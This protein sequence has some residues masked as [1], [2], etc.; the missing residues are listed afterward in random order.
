LRPRVH[1]SFRVVGR[2]RP[3]S[4]NPPCPLSQAGAITAAAAA[5]LGETA[6]AADGDEAAA[7][8]VRALCR[9]AV[10]DGGAAEPAAQAAAGSALCKLLL[11]GRAPQALAQPCAASA[12]CALFATQLPANG[13]VGGVGGAPEDESS[14]PLGGMR[15]FVQVCEGLGWAG[16]MGS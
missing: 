15:Q 11:L 6:G 1:D 9:A 10:R 14:E 8:C 5:A 3:S 12:L 2:A 4:H 16:R 13:A 7:E